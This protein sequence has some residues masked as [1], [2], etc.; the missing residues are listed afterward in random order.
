MT[1]RVFVAADKAVFRYIPA[2]LNSALSVTSRPLQVGIMYEGVTK[3]SLDSLVAKFPAIDFNFFKIPP[4]VIS[5]LPTKKN[6][7]TVAFARLLMADMVSWEKFVYLDVDILV[8]KDLAELYDTAIGEHPAAAVV[9]HSGINSGVMVIN[10][11]VWRARKLSGTL[12]DYARIHQPK[13]ADQGTMQAVIGSEIQP[14]D[15]RW[16][17]LVDSMWGPRDT[18]PDLHIEQAW[19]LHFI[20]G[21]KPWNLGRLKMPKQYTKLWDGYSDTTGMPRDLR[22]DMRLVVWQLLMLV[23]R[24]TGKA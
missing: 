5:Q 19:I 17:T 21:F 14:L 8:R 12:L 13:E 20:T 22:A 16:N 24:F 23:R 15:G 9:M 3:R 7:S 1:V 4:S 11:A 10:A 6:I 18:N 2:V